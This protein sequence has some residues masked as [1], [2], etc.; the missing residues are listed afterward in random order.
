MR[1]FAQNCEL[2]AEV[3]DGALVVVAGV[4][5]L[6]LELDPL[7]LVVTVGARVVAVGTLVNDRV[8]LA[9]PAVEASASTAD[10]ASVPAGMTTPCFVSSSFEAEFWLAPTSEDVVESC[11]AGESDGAELWLAPTFEAASESWRTGKSDGAEPWLAPT[12]EEVVEPCCTGE[13]DGAEPWLA[14]T[15]EEVVEPSCTGESDGAEP[16]L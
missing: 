14:P 8:G 7:E 6:E 1:G 15:S 13:S 12:S 16:W 11:C 4:V 2:S 10:G 9:S 3:V 5:E